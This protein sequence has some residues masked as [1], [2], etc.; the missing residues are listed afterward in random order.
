MARGA[1][2]LG[3]NCQPGFDAVYPFV[4]DTLDLD[5][6]RVGFIIVQIKNDPTVSDSDILSWFRQMDPF[7]CKLLD[8]SDKDGDNLFPIPI[9]RI[10]FSLSTPKKEA[11][12]EGSTFTH[13]T[14][15]VP[16]QGTATFGK[17]GR[18]A[19]T[20]YDFICKG[21]NERDLRVVQD[22]PD[23]WR[24]LANKREPWREFYNVTAP[25]VLRTQMP[26][27]GDH[28]AHFSSWFD[29]HVNF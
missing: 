13:V 24:S 25:D 29:G 27:C 6:K 15:E 8:D 3:A 28:E 10:V 21:I 5:V 26:G 14:Y 7:I 18:P 11:K 9:I 2:T 16:S 17:D 4:Y 12:K 23:A 1:A 19:F 20:S 22:A